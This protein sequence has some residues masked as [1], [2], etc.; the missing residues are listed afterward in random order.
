MIYTNFGRLCIITLAFT[1]IFTAFEATENFTS[2]ALRDDDFNNLGFLSLALL[3][4][5]FALCSFFSTAIVNK[6]K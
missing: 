3:Y 5:V 1:F 2:K 4:L 6:L